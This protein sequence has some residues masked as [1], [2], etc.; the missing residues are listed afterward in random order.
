M[1]YKTRRALH[2][3]IGKWYKIV[4]EGAPDRGGRDCA[5]CLMF[6]RNADRDCCEGCPVAAETGLRRCAGT[7]YKDWT[8]HHNLRH[9]YK[10]KPAQRKVECKICYTLAFKELNFLSSLSVEDP[11]KVGIKLNKSIKIPFTRCPLCNTHP[12]DFSSWAHP[13]KWNTVRHG[14][15]ATC[16]ACGK[17]SNITEDET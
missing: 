9:H 5:L 14:I 3:S 2:E 8:E 13:T 1:D 10:S 11:C 7:P 17:E 16:H 15:V 12:M 4:H 6:T